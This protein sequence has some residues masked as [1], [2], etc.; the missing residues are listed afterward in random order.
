VTAPATLAQRPLL[1]RRIVVTRPRAQAVRL[2]ALLEG[3]GAEVFALP[4]IGIEPPE[5]PRPLDEAL[6]RLDRFDWIVFTSA[7]GVDA[8]R[9]RLERTGRDASALAG[10]RLAA[11]GPETA[12]VLER[13]GWPVETVPSEFR[14][15]GLVE[16]LRPHL[17]P[18]AE[19]LLVRAAE[20]REVLPREL[21]ALGAR[22]TVAPAY[23]TVPLP[24]GGPDVRALL[25]ARRVDVVT[26]TSSSTVRGFLALLPADAYRRLLR[27]LVLAAIGPITAATL[28]EHG[29]EAAVVPRDYTVTAL[30]AAIAAHFARSQ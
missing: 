7:N 23:R 6:G 30:A 29:L 3:Y 22:V 4:A 10:V 26:F 21:A 13:A 19:V 17:R 24:D 9:D 2:V 20:A 18:G 8:F 16:A 5:D 15:E 1:G 14:A 25:Q 12:A 28:G 27:G 11:I